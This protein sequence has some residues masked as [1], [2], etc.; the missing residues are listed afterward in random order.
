[1]GVRNGRADS[2]LDLSQLPEVTATLAAGAEQHDRD[3]SFP[4]DGIKAVHEAGLLTA[5][6][7]RHHGGPGAGLAD[8]VR[9]LRALGTGDPSVA[10]I[11]AMTLIN[12]A[13]Q[14]DRADL[15]S[16]RL[17]ERDRRVEGPAGAY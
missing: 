7:A 4:A 2:A 8:A 15:A 12:H 10:L 13:M 9:I 3:G 5:T 16:G 17:R 11:T 1:M 14:A 6:V